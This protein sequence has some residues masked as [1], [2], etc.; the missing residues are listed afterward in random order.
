MKLSNYN[1]ITPLDHDKFIIHN[2]VS[3][4]FL[5]CDDE[6]MAFFNNLRNDINK[7]NYNPKEIRYL[8]RL[9]ENDVLIDT[10]TSEI[11]FLNF[12]Y[13]EEKFKSDTLYITLH[14]N[15]QCSFR[16]ENC[17]SKERNLRMDD[18]S[19]KRILTFIK[20]TL[21]HPKLHIAIYGGDVLLELNQL[22]KLCLE[23]KDFCITKNIE[24]SASIYSNGYLM[25]KAA[26]DTLISLSIKKIYISLPYGE[27]A[28]YKNRHK[29]YL[30]KIYDTISNNIITI[31]DS[32]LDLSV[33]LNRTDYNEE[34]LEYFTLTI[35]E[36][37]RNKITIFINFL[38][39]TNYIINKFSLYKSLI[40]KNYKIEVFSKNFRHCPVSSTNHFFIESNGKI[41]TCPLGGFKGEYYG[42]ID[43]TGNFILSNKSLYYKVK[44][45]PMMKSTNCENCANLPNHTGDCIF[46]NH[47]DKNL[48]YYNS[49][50]DL[51]LNEKILLN[52]YNELKH[53]PQFEKFFL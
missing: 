32:G 26:I 21:N 13:S 42:Y 22:S 1:V 7:S 38:I 28:H 6:F 10:N 51:N 48:C 25:N 18:N 24:F 35:P 16:C 11:D 31:L 50:D 27:D 4:K 17:Y 23:L 46:N 39:K 53:N 52:Y 12:K 37:Y 3:N 40:D 19:M 30:K 34:E 2:T 14:T 15:L 29:S 5:I 9:M 45:M 44:N 8:L 43:E 20:K 33:I 36:K 47:Y 41:T 49:K